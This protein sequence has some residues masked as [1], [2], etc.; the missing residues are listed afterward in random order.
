M[1][2]QAEED[3]SGRRWTSPGFRGWCLQGRGDEEGARG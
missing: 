1:T 2:R 3:Y